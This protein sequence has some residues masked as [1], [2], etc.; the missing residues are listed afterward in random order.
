MSMRYYRECY[1]IN[2][3]MAIVGLFVYIYGVSYISITMVS[4]PSHV[5][6]PHIVPCI[7][8]TTITRTLSTYSAVHQYHNHHTYALHIQC[9]A[10][11][12][13]PSHARSPHIVPCI[14]TTT[15]TRTL[16]TYR[17]VHKYF[18][19]PQFKKRSPQFKKTKI[20]LMCF[21]NIKKK[22][23][24][25]KMTDINLFNCKECYRN[26]NIILKYKVQW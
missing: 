10:L 25:H 24:Q 8:I 11:V 26:I 14:S 21:D 9:R 6:S 12:P 13:Q 18:N 15:I 17:A 2:F 16:S 4:Q 20:I 5:R 22:N 7:S 3:I 1:S 23:S 19:H